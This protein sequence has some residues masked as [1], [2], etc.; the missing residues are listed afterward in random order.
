VGGAGNDYLDG[1]GPKSNGYYFGYDSLVGGA[2]ADTLLG[3]GYSDYLS[4]G[5]G[6][7]FLDGGGYYSDTLLGDDGKD[8]LIW[9]PNDTRISG[10]SGQDMLRTDWSLNLTKI[11]NSLTEDIEI[12]QLGDS[13]VYSDS[14]R[15]TLTLKKADL[16]DLSSTTDKL[17]VLGDRGDAVDIVGSFKDRGVSGGF[18]KYKLGAGVLLVDTDITDVG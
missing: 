13:S 18:H 1:E 7:D 2:G 9:D 4:G 3:G 14:G 16:L 5:S 8:T 11:D 12:I 15:D 6:A 10:G 17:K